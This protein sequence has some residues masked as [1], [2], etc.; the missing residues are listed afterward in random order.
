M[1]CSIKIMPAPTHLSPFYT[2]M[3]VKLLCKC[4]YATSEQR[5]CHFRDTSV[6][7]LHYKFGTIVGYNLFYCIKACLHSEVK[8]A[9]CMLKIL[10][11]DTMHT[12]PPH[13]RPTSDPP[14]PLVS[15]HTFVSDV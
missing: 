7:P 4:I 1:Q 10:C 6:P 9:L 3:Q 12:I 13:S 15:N 14:Q 11:K 2:N 8:P 5:N